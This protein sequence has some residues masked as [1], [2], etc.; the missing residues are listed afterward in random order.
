MVEGREVAR[1]N[2]V[3]HLAKNI[4]SSR[5]YF[6]LLFSKSLMSMVNKQCHDVTAMVEGREVARLNRVTH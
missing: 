4:Y 6:Y 2:R 5:K 1:L 3:A